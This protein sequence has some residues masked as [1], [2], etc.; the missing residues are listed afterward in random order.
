MAGLVVPITHTNSNRI[1]L[2]SESNL[3]YQKMILIDT[4]LHQCMLG[5]SLGDY[6]LDPNS[7]MINKGS[8]AEQFWG[9]EYIKYSSPYNTNPL[10][11]WQREQSYSNA[12]VD[13]VIQKNL[14]II[15]VEIKSSGSGRMQSL[16]LFLKE[17]NK[18]VRYRFS[19]ENFS[20]IEDIK[21]FPLYAV[22]NLLS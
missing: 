16:R 1:P 4:G 19:L 13:Y 17:K 8:L 12:E 15:P 3:K 7:I 9:L 10:Y 14:E 11:Y 2:G 18:N 6:L 20:E 22:S 5:L 21:I